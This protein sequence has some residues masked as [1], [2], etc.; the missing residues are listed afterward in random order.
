MPTVTTPD[1]ARRRREERPRRPRKRRERTDESL[2]EWNDLAGEAA[3]QEREEASFWERFSTPRFALVVGMLVAAGVL[4][5]G[6]VHATRALL[7]D[8]ERARAENRRLHL[9]KSRLQSAYDRATAPS[10]IYRRADE[11]GLEKGLG[12]EGETIYVSPPDPSA[13]SAAP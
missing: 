12:R 7:S 1:R 8:V 13:T 4:Y 10:V 9:K 5:I 6:H 11:L 3:P 2:P